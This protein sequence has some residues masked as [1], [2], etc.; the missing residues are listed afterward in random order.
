M[1]PS[2]GF[3]HPILYVW[4]EESS[5]PSHLR[6]VEQVAEDKLVERIV[7]LYNVN[8]PYSTVMSR[9]KD[10]YCADGVWEDPLVF[11]QGHEEIAG[12]YLSLTSFISSI[13]VTDIEVHSNSTGDKYTIH[14]KQ[15]YTT[16]FIPIT[17]PL[18]V[19]STIFL[20]GECYFL[21]QPHSYMYK[22]ICI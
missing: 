19:V 13:R 12:N 21:W 15:V 9:V 8:V 2:V 5:S 3:S 20:D 7:Q 14:C 18:K 17:I 6:H 11:C 1:A 16:R 22:Q 10:L 4:I